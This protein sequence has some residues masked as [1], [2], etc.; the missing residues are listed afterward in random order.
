MDQAQAALEQVREDLDRRL[1]L[2]A[3]G[4]T[5]V[6]ERDVEVLENELDLREGALD[7][8]RAGVAVS[9]ARVGCR[10]STRVG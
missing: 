7:A 4:S 8:T 2:Q 1:T 10:K 5:V 6:S 9:H 3:R